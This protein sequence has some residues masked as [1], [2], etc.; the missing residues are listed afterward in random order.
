LK[1]AR[2][3]LSALQAFQRSLRAAD[4]RLGAQLVAP[5]SPWFAGRWREAEPR[6]LLVELVKGS[7]QGIA[8][9]DKTLA[10]LETR[11]VPL[12][13]RLLAIPPDRRP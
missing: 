2:E 3:A 6:A 1:Q 8:Q 7:R 12:R 10:D 4:G 13:A 11:V 9:F 5:F